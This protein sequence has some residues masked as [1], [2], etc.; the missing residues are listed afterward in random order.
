MWGSDSGE[1]EYYVIRRCDAVYV[2][3]WALTFSEEQLIL[4]PGKLNQKSVYLVFQ[5]DS[6]KGLY[7][8]TRLYGVTFVKSVVLIRATNTR[9]LTS[10]ERVR[11]E[12]CR[13][14]VFVAHQVWRKDD[15]T[16]CVT[17]IIYRRRR[18]GL[19]RRRWQD[20][21][22]R[23]CGKEFEISAESW[24]AIWEVLWILLR[25]SVV[26]LET[27]LTVLMTASDHYKTPTSNCSNL[28]QFPQPAFQSCYLQPEYLCR[29][30]TPVA[31]VVTCTRCGT[32]YRLLCNDQFVGWVT[33]ESGL[34][35]VPAGGGEALEPTQ[36]LVTCM[37]SGY[38]TRVK[39]SG[40]WNYPF[41]DIN[42]SD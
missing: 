42:A 39:R 16:A 12:V 8:S 19:E 37:P 18:N 32:Q 15:K 27:M 1:Y 13:G 29:N 30:V 36:I 3:Q 40:A 33:R 5:R 2:C 35:W 4:S 9:R 34:V 41:A 14:R 21:L 7:L 38:S 25:L 26:S 17:R 28:C 22:R 20:A 23:D 10:E 31:A 6:R 11:L 24:R